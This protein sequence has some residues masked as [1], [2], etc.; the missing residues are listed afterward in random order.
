MLPNLG[1][2]EIVE[3]GSNYK[4][5]ALRF[6]A[7]VAVSANHLDAIQA[8]LCLNELYSQLLVRRKLSISG[9]FW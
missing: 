3:N 8:R 5:E 1:E 4:L 2:S 6:M 7:D 9:S